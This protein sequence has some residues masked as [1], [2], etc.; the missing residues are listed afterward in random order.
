MEVKYF[1]IALSRIL[2]N[3]V[4]WSD[5]NSEHIR[6]RS[7]RYGD[8]EFDIEAEW[9]TEAVF[10]EN[11]IVGIAGGES[12]SLEVIGYSDSARELLKVWLYPEDL[13]RGIWYGASACKANT[14]DRRNYQEVDQNE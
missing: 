5:D 2:I 1:G 9:A 7:K 11:R 3:G 13:D 10:D 14:T 8:K 4:R 6:T 12:D